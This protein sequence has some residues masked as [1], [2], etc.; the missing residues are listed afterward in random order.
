MSGHPRE[1][2]AGGAREVP[3]P[4]PPTRALPRRA[5]PRSRAR[6]SSSPWPPGRPRGGGPASPG[7]PR[8]RRPR[9]RGGGA[10]PASQSS[11]QGPPPP[12]RAPPPPARRRRSDKGACRVRSCA[13]CARA[14]AEHAWTTRRTE[15]CEQF[16]SSRLPLS[17]TPSF[18][19]LPFARRRVQ[20]ARAQVTR[21][22]RSRRTPR[23]PS[24]HGP[25][26]C[27]DPGLSRCP[28]RLL[29]LAQKTKTTMAARDDPPPSASSYLRRLTSPLAGFGQAPGLPRSAAGVRRV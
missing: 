2:K 24:H 27:E 9:R 6:S 29:S 22:L 14:R 25:R 8:G 1:D 5:A 13:E 18:F 10:A 4:L 20:R 26:T 12:R 19:L 23:P 3:P 28:G 21:L 16:A 11:S 15:L 7:G 17:L